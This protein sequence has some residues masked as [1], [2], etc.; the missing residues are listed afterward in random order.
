MFLICCKVYFSNIFC[1]IFISGL[2]K[3]LQKKYR[4]SIFNNKILSDSNLVQRYSVT[5]KSGCITVVRFSKYT[6][7]IDSPREDFFPHKPLIFRFFSRDA[8]EYAQLTLDFKSARSQSK[9]LVIT[10]AYKLMCG[11]S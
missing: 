8:V 1:L 9:F 5:L 3:K 7:L 6:V 4:K 2:Y 11:R 10:F